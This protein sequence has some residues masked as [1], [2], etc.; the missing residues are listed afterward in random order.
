MAKPKGKVYSRGHVV[1]YTMVSG[2]T[3]KNTDTVFGRASKAS[4]I[5]VNGLINYRKGLV[6]TSGVMAMFMKVSGTRI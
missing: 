6:C 4:L 1:R 2:I 5:S 3:A